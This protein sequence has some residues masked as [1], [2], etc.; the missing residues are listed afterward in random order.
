MRYWPELWTM[1]RR[2]RRAAHMFKWST[3]QAQAARVWRS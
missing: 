2:G 1:R 3:I